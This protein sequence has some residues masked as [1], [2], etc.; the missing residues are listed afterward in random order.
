MPYVSSAE[1]EVFVSRFNR[2]LAILV[3]AA[4]AAL[5][6]GLLLSVQDARLLYIV[7]CALFAFVA[8][9]MLWRPSFT[10]ADDG[11]TA[12]NVTRTVHVPWEALIHVD[13]KYALTLYTPG[14]KYPVWAAPAPGTARTLRATRNETKGRI[15]RPSVEDTVRR[16]GDLL[17]TESGAAAEVVR[18][19]WTQLQD[20]GVLE[21]GRADSTPVTVRWHIASL[22]VLVLL[23]AGAVAALLLA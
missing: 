23:A 12:V 14:H 1:R 15:G 5:A 16:P 6:V 4:A 18:R 22:V 9:A 20:A 3:W 2:V 13:T 8:W 7:P 19:R 21:A 17:S 10:V 11:L